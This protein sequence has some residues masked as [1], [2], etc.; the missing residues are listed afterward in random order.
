M[1]LQQPF[2]IVTTSTDGAV[3]E[4]LAGAETSFTSG[5]ICRLTHYSLQGVRLALSR[6]VEQG[7]VLSRP[8]GRAYLYQ[9]NRQHLAA[10]YVE[11]IAHI[12]SEFL[13]SLRELLGSWE[14][15]PEMA[16]LFGSAS[17]GLM[18]LDSDIDIFLVRPAVVPDEDSSWRNQVVELEQRSSMWTGNDCRVFELSEAELRQGL[19]RADQVLSDIARDGIWLFGERIRLVGTR[20]V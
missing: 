16:A 4:V 19:E 10:K 17:R 18:R 12:F 13:D 1:Q 11:G 20:S 8:A 6:L 3:L 5:Q 14:P 2:G 7:I 9:L 15:R